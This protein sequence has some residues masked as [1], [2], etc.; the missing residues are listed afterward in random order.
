MTHR[1]RRRE[2]GLGR[3][4]PGPNGPSVVLVLD[5]APRCSVSFL[6]DLAHPTTSDFP[7]AL[8]KGWYLESFLPSGR[9]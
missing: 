7:W 4:L 3:G 5:P 6:G 1:K 8:E 2:G 9:C